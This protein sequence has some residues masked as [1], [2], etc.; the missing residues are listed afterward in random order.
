MCVGIQEYFTGCDDPGNFIRTR[1]CERW[2]QGCTIR[3]EE[4]SVKLPGLCPRC[5]DALVI[6]LPRREAANLRQRVS[7]RWEDFS[8]LSDHYYR[9]IV[10]LRRFVEAAQARYDRTGGR[11]DWIGLQC[12]ITELRA[13]EEN[14]HREA[15]RYRMDEARLFQEQV[16]AENAETH[17]GS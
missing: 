15:H 14:Y 7:A 11:K 4:R 1:Q 17:G 3:V 10:G 8:E 13:T 2:P 16:S 12:A 5:R 6:H 9:M